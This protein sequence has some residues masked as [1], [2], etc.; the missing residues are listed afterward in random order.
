MK[1]RKA[2]SACVRKLAQM[3]ERSSIPSPYVTLPKHQAP[4]QDMNPGGHSQP[5]G[6]PQYLAARRCSECGH[7][8]PPNFMPPPAEPWTIGIC[9]CSQD[10]ESCMTGLFC[11]CVLYG[12]NS[13]SLANEDTSGRCN[14]PCIF[15]GICVEGGIALGALTT[16]AIFSGFYYFPGLEFLICEGL[17]CGWCLCGV[18]TS[19]GRLSLQKKYHLKDSP[20]NP[21]CVHCC[22]HWCALCQEHR[23]MKQR[24]PE[25]I[26]SP[27]F[28]VDPPPVQ[29]MKY[30][31][32]RENYAVSSSSNREHNKHTLEMQ[33]MKR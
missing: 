26:L 13:A 17:L 19:L 10:R 1:H 4:L 9:A 21:C 14:K 22:L 32:N 18:C 6:V 15:H 16:C 29:E 7:A 28:T 31:D 3:E 27:I 33:A 25:S 24:L 20:C 12:R 8:I 11:P 30:T 5:I 23:E 2:I